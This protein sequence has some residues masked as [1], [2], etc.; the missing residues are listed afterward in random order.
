MPR[1][2]N[3]NAGLQ[4]MSG[5]MDQ[6]IAKSA[7]MA[8]AVNRAR[9]NAREAQKDFDRLDQIIDN[10]AGAALGFSQELALQM[11][12]V[13]IGALDLDKFI[14]MWGDAKVATADGVKTIR[15]LFYGA[16]LGKYRQQIQDLITD[17][18]KGAADLDTVITFLKDN[19]G[20]VAVGL[21]DILELFRQGKASLEDVQ[22][23]LDRSKAAFDGVE[24]DALA[25]M[26]RQ[27]I[28]D[29]TFG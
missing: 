25:E 5:Q 11:Q 12:A 1:F 15:E 17:V 26:I 14:N 21:I 27:R 4:E 29:G 22:A 18:R 8:E 9:D 19:A 3:T 16:D 20:D 28:L 10:T 24:F 13:K 6:V 23:V 7:T 2:G